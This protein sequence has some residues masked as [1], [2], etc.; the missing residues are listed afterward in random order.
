M[1]RIKSIVCNIGER[2]IDSKLLI[3][4]QLGRQMDSTENFKYC[5]FEIK[6]DDKFVKNSTLTMDSDEFDDIPRCEINPATSQ[7]ISL[8]SSSAYAATTQSDFSDEMRCSS[9]SPQHGPNNQPHIAD[10]PKCGSC[11]QFNDAI[12]Y[13]NECES[14]L[15]QLCDYA[16]KQMKCFQQHQICI[17]EEKQRQN[18]PM[19]E[20]KFCTHH[21]GSPIR[22][23]CWKCRQFICSICACNAHAN[24]QVATVEEAQK[25]LRESI[26]E[27][28]HRS[29]VQA[30]QLMEKS[31]FLKGHHV[32]ISRDVEVAKSAIQMAYDK[33]LE[34][35]R[36]C[37]NENLVKL[38][39]IVLKMSELSAETDEQIK[40]LAKT[41]NAAQQNLMT[42]SLL[43]LIQVE[44]RI[45]LELAKISNESLHDDYDLSIKFDSDLM[46]DA[47]S[48]KDIFGELKVVKSIE[49]EHLPVDCVLANKRLDGSS[50][51]P[52]TLERSSIADLMVIDS[53]QFIPPISPVFRSNNS[54]DMETSTIATMGRG[55]DS[56]FIMDSDKELNVNIDGG[57]SAYSF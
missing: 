30:N 8:Q 12:S 53:G 42:A 29:D 20:L 50:F 31:N 57:S 49:R 45:G 21:Q 1:Q 17:L 11:H 48:V 6:G 54:L 43:D 36:Q 26:K 33:I 47:E 14:F 18:Q 32:K 25:S 28:I 3:D 51:A 2:L 39:K 41:K 23:Y 56:I 27:M 46:F 52:S 44:N 22:F 4:R 9:Q 55:D 13:C 15:C 34:A 38:E 37:R 7:S 10:N 19:K 5:D 35:M 24:H 16:H 40:R